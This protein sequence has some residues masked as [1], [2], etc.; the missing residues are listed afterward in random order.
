VIAEIA[1]PNYDARPAE[2]PIDMLVLHYTGMT[3]AADALARLTEPAAG[4]SAHWLIDEDGAVVRL[5]PEAMRAWHAGVSFWRGATDIN[6]RSIGIELVN[7]GHEFGYRPF[8][9]PQ[10]AALVELASGIVARHPIPPRNV[11]GHSDVAPRRKMDPGELFDW[12]RLARAGVGLWPEASAACLMDEDAVR[13]VLS[14]IGYETEDLFATLKAFQRHFRPARVDGRLD[15][16]TARLIR[17]LA[18]RCAATS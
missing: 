12:R 13:L 3:S 14:T 17:A 18:D 5:V 9:E 1:S 6:A 15:R 11:V 16:E 4:V 2:T 10:M 7:P 8:P